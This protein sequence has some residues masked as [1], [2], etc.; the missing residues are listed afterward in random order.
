MPLP[1]R[2]T[3]DPPKRVRVIV[4]GPFKGQEGRVT[5]VYYDHAHTG[6]SADRI[7]VTLDSGKDLRGFG[8][9]FEAVEELPAMADV[10]PGA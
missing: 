1:E 9:S 7:F 6:I 10:C 8:P 4:D 3:E 2:F 5:M